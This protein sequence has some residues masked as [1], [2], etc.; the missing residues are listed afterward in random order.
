MEKLRKYWRLSWSEQ[1]VLVRAGLLL[2]AAEAGLCLLPFRILLRWVQRPRTQKDAA[3][4]ASPERISYLVEVA[5][6]HLFQARLLGSWLRPTCLQKSLALCALL[7]RRGW[8]ARLVI[9]TGSPEGKFQAHAWVELDGQI[10]GN[11]DTQDYTA[12]VA[13][14][15]PAAWRQIA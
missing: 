2:V 15:R 6:R 11:T 8:D 14:A 13:F 5:A 4:R 9:G 12:L 1:R 7:T 10:L 3:R